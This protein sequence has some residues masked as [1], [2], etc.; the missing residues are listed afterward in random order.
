MGVHDGHRERLKERFAE[1]GLDDFN[2]LNTLELLLFYAIPRHDTN[3]LAHRLLERFGTI[4]AVFAA[5][6]RELTAVEGIG[7]NA[8]LLITLVPQI[9]KRCSVASTREQKWIR[10][11]AEAGKFLVP[12]LMYEKSEKALLVC[13]DSFRRILSVTEL[14]EGVVNEVE[15]NARKIVEIAL[16][17]RASSVILAHNHPDGVALP[18]YEDEL[19]TRKVMNALELVN[20]TL[21]DH[22]V[23]GEDDYISFADSGYLRMLR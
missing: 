15:L 13:L 16:K 22:I 1:H 19:A 18:S 21:Q 7:K 20:I 14:G 5:S 17:N 12:R 6:V 9:N 2:E 11:S 10:S 8:A 4:E 23:V 3:V